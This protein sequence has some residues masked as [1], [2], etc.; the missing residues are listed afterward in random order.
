MVTLSAR[1][2]LNRVCFEIRRLERF[3]QSISSS[4]VLDG[5][6]AFKF[7]PIHQLSKQARFGAGLKKAVE[8][9]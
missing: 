9:P 1:L 4:A 6:P 8:M 5:W 2:S 3:S 7:T